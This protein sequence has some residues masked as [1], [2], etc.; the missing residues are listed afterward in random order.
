MMSPTGTCVDVIVGFPG[1][2]QEEFEKTYNFLKEL[3]IS[4]LHVFTYS[5]RA[6]TTAFKS[7]EKVP[8]GIRKNRSRELQALS[9]RKKRLFYQQHI[10]SNKSVLFESKHENDYVTG[11]TENYIKVKIKDKPDIIN[12]V[13]NVFLKEV[14][15]DGIILCE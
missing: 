6:K 15:S 12:S 4:Y 7:E 3:D 8:M 1:E 9:E 14:H 10:Q 13:K 11:F 2:T 5:E